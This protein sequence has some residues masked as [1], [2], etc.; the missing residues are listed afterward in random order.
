MIITVYSTRW[1]LSFAVRVKKSLSNLSRPI[2]LTQWQGDLKNALPSW[3]IIDYDYDWIVMWQHL[4][5]ADGRCCD[6]AADDRNGSAVSLVMLTA[7]LL[8]GRQQEAEGG[9]GVVRERPPMLGDAI[10]LRSRG[11]P[12]NPT[13]SSTF[14]FLPPPQL[15]CRSGCDQ[16][17][18][19]VTDKIPILEVWAYERYYKCCQEC[20][21]TNGIQRRRQYNHLA[22]THPH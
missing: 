18:C 16:V 17:S 1:R 2:V 6:T 19:Q 9:D 11:A 7:A 14:I 13:S 3:T 20:I 4:L 12:T 22:T 10:G 21:Q 5:N 8:L 15:Y